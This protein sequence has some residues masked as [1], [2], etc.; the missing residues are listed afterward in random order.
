MMGWKSLL[1]LSFAMTPFYSDSG[2]AQTLITSDD[3]ENTFTLFTHTGPGNFYSGLSASYYSPANSPFA[4]SGTY[5]YGFSGD[6]DTLTSASINTSAFTSVQ[7]SIR[8]ASFSTSFNTGADLSDYVTVEVSPDDGLHY[9]PTAQVTGNLNAWWSYA[10]GVANASTPYD[11]DPSPVTFSPAGGGNR[12]S[13][14]YSTITITGLPESLKLRVR[15]LLHNDGSYFGELWV[16]DQFRIQGN[17]V[18]GPLLT[19][20]PLALNSFYALVGSPSPEQVYQVSGSNLANDIAVAAPAGYSISGT[21]GSGFGSSINLSPSGGIVTPTNIFVRLDGIATGAFNSTVTHTSAGATARTVTVRGNT[22]VNEPT[23]PGTVSIS[24]I[25]SSSMNVQF[26]GGNGE[27]R[28]VVLRQGSPVSAQPVDAMD[29][30]GNLVFGSGSPLA[31]G[32]YVVYKGSGSTV[33]VT[34]LVAN[35]PYYISVFEYN[36]GGAVEARNYQ[37]TAGTGNATTLP[38]EQGLNVTASDSIFTID[39]DNTVD[40]VNVGAFDG[41]TISASPSAGQ[42]NSYA[43]SYSL[44]TYDGTTAFGGEDNSGGGV[45][46]GNVSS[47]GFYAFE[48]SSGNR[49]LGLQLTNIATSRS[50]TL[51]VLN[52]TGTTITSLA[53]SFKMYV[54]NNSDGATDVGF[55]VSS[56]NQ[57][58]Y[59]KVNDTTVIVSETSPGWK[60]YLRTIRVTDLSVIN[61]DA[62]YLRWYGYSYN[63]QPQADEIGIDDIAVVANPVN[64]APRISG[65]FE[66]MN[67]RGPVKL[68]GTTTVSGD[69]L[70]VQDQLQLGNVDLTVSG[71]VESVSGG[72]I[73]TNGNGKLIITNVTTDRAFPVGNSS[74]NPLTITNG[75]GLT[76]SVNL[77][78]GINTTPTPYYVNRAVSRTWKITPSINPTPAGATLIFGYNDGDPG[79][80]GSNFNTNEAVQVWH[81]EGT[82][83]LLASGTLTPTGTA[84]GQRTVSLTNWMQYSLFAI[85][86]VSGP[87]PVHFSS[88]RASKINNTIRVSWE[89]LSEE[90]IA[91]YNVEKSVDGT[92]FA[93]VA[94]ILPTANNGGSAKYDWSDLVPET[95]RNYYRIVA[96]ELSGNKEYSVVV[97]VKPGQPDPGIAIYP[98]PVPGSRITLQVSDI[99]S[100]RYQLRMFSSVGQLALSQ[101]IVHPGGSQAVPVDLG[102]SIKS[103]TYLIILSGNNLSI[104]TLMIRQ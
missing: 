78:D 77:N 13:D 24:S 17:P 70:L 93:P 31:A 40:R 102:S 22:L 1:R 65:N 99:A 104:N 79:Q 83:W 46:T 25:T 64:A 44:A 82:G 42:L 28:L 8:L 5:A 48:T 85:S 51:R 88:V 94:K 11:G 90:N 38:V 53:I 49:S 29:Y 18:T 86:N 35:R 62:L 91:Y 7:L 100:G 96:V 54:L 32:E 27:G 57:D 55:A 14:G 52:S 12:T 73:N 76:W 75:S 43:W 36:D 23:I 39:F 95:A 66:N 3:F 80:V 87:L 59:T 2:S 58:Y 81:Y 45:S 41:T 98:N 47:P 20:Y 56:N 72:Y 60:S 69:V 15:I 16:I 4:A 50:L 34:G 67:I 10:G 6:I 103:G 9:Y 30:T 19:V 21:S 101:S 92:S 71:N 89:N 63:S 97:M 84:G 61:G 37:S 33:T 68:S 26:G 74:Y